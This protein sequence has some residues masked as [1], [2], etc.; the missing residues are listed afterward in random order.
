MPSK[1]LQGSTPPV[2][3]P[4]G[5]SQ[6]TPRGRGGTQPARLGLLTYSTV[7]YGLCYVQPLRSK[8][9]VAHLQTG[10]LHE[11]PDSASLWARR[12]LDPL[13]LSFFPLWWFYLKLC[14][15]KFILSMNQLLLIFIDLSICLFSPY[16]TYF[17]SI[18]FFLLLI[19]GL[20]S[21]S[22]FSSFRCKLS[23]FEIFLVS[24]GRSVLLW[25]SLLELL[26]LYPID[27]GMSHFNFH[28]P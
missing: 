21:S 3:T 16:F 28:F 11:L 20:T 2:W 19:L 25:T 13:S 17:H 24:W 4:T 18:I 26:L 8:A 15:L 9:A 22:L 7:R 14:Q 5:Q 12:W 10:T 1:V 23:L 27:F 6:L